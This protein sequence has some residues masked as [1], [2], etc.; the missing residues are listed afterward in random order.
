MAYSSNELAHLKYNL[1]HQKGL[2]DEQATERIA[3]LI[4]WSDELEKKIKKEG[5]KR[6]KE[7]EAKR[8]KV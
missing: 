2:T 6:N 4:L 8:K 5:E 1:I 3:N 7:E